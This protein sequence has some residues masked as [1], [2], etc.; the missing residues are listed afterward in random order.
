MH[1]YHFWRPFWHVFLPL[2]VEHR[3]VAGKEALLKMQGVQG[4]VF[5]SVSPPK[6]L[7]PSCAGE[8]MLCSGWHGLL[9]TA[10]AW[11]CCGRFGL[12]FGSTIYE[13]GHRGTAVT[14]EAIK[15]RVFSDIEHLISED[16]IRYLRYFKIILKF[17]VS[18]MSF[19]NLIE[20]GW[21]CLHYIDITLIMVTSSNLHVDFPKHSRRFLH[22]PHWTAA[23]VSKL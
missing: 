10:I 14:R 1:F 8:C 11:P 2:I 3:R 12:G 19:F 6:S 21:T 13:T 4:D 16:I 15:S 18:I 9:V 20:V 23:V 17:C 5:G 7:G 22:H